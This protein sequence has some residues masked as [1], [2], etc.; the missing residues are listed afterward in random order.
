MSLNTKKLIAQIQ[1][2]AQKNATNKTNKIEH[3][4]ASSRLVQL[5]LHEFMNATGIKMDKYLVDK[6]YH[7]IK[8]DI[9]IYL[10][11]ELIKWCGYSG[12][13]K[14]QKQNLIKLI[15]KLNVP[16][17]EM[18]NDEYEKFRNNVCSQTTFKKKPSSIDTTRN[19]C[20]INTQN[21]HNDVSKNNMLKQH[22]FEKI[23]NTCNINTQNEYNDVS[24]NKYDNE[25]DNESGNE[26]DNESD[27]ESNNDMFDT[28]FYKV[29]PE[30]DRSNGKNRTKHILIMPDDFRMIVMMLHTSR[31]LQ[32]CKYYIELEKLIKYYVNYQLQFVS[33]REELLKID[34]KESREMY[35]KAEADR[36]K[37]EADRTKA[38]IDRIQANSDRRELQITLNN[39]QNELTDLHDLVED[40][41]EEIQNLTNNLNIATEDRVPKTERR[42]LRERFVLMQLHDTDPEVH[43]YYVIRAQIRSVNAAINRITLR[44]PNAIQV[45]T[46]FSQPNAG[47]LYS[48][49]KERL[50]DFIEYTGNYISPIE[51]THNQFIRRI[52][53]INNE[54]RNV[55]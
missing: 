52:H 48:R 33:R 17:I 14:I 3:A 49:I 29:Y 54:R 45:L 24:K 38:E 8:E 51:L 12:E 36:T 26:S 30:V 21:E 5:S 34:L 50:N 16:I 19:T 27:N 44:F 41:N 11:N 7:S 35:K 13:L 18:N 40:S 6:F 1:S 53:R 42:S 31:G 10:D 28:D 47:N 39:V 32:V 15:K 2:N 23:R 37:A 25:S 55:E 22:P 20:N 43:E 9:P 4:L 46:I